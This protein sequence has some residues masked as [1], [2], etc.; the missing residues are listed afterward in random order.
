MLVPHGPFV[1]VRKPALEV[2]GLRVDAPAPLRGSTR[3]R[4]LSYGDEAGGERRRVER[5]PP[6]DASHLEPQ[7]SQRL[8]LRDVPGLLRPVPVVGAVASPQLYEYEAMVPGAAS[9]DADPLTEALKPVAVA[10][11]EA[12]GDG[13]V[14][15]PVAAE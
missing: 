4:P 1:P 8:L 14:A 11:N 5:L 10:V 6:G 7:L 13:L 3:Q 2:E 15:A 12:V 9:L